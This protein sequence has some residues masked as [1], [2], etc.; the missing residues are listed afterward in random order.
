MSLKTIGGFQRQLLW[1][2]LAY[3]SFLQMC[4]DKS[5]VCIFSPGL[6]RLGDWQEGK[7]NFQGGTLSFHPK[8]SNTSVCQCCEEARILCRGCLLISPLRSTAEVLGSWNYLQAYDRRC[9]ITFSL[10]LSTTS[11]GVS[12]GKNFHAVEIVQNPFKTSP[13]G[14]PPYN[15][16]V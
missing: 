7:G 3:T 12:S 10:P 14:L 1:C 15:P 2:C 13:T 11:L 16:W 8:I 4:F 9:L 6:N 5:E